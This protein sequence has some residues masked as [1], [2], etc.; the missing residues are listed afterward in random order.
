[1]N[2]ALRLITSSV[3]VAVLLVV[4]SG[5]A[6]IAFGRAAVA[7]RSLAADIYEP[8]DTQLQASTLAAGAPQDHTFHV[9]GDEDWAQFPVLAGEVVTVTTSNLEAGVDT[10]VTFYSEEGF[11]LAS[12]DDD[13]VEVSSR[14]TYVSTV[15]GFL[16]VVAEDVSATATGAYTLNLFRYEDEF[17]VDDSPAEASTLLPGLRQDHTFNRDGD[18]DWAQISV[19]AGRQYT[20]Y[21]SQLDLNVDTILEIYGSDTL[22]L[23]ADNDDGGVD[24]SSR[25][26]YTATQTGVNYVKVYQ[27]GGSGSGAYKL[28]LERDPGVYLN[29]DQ[30]ADVFTYSPSTGD[31]AR[32]AAD[33]SGGFTTVTGSWSPDWS[34]QPAQFN[35]DALTDFFLFNSSS[36]Q[37]FRMIDNGADGF[38]T[39]DTGFWWQGWE[40]YILDLNGD[41]ISDFFLYDPS[42]GTWFRSITTPTGF[43]YEQ[44][45]W[46][47]DWEIYP[48]KLNQDLLGDLFLINRTTGRWFW[49]YG[50]IDSGFSYPATETWFP[51]WVLYPGD[52]NGDGLDDLLLHDPPTGTYFVATTSDLGF[53][54]VQGG[55]SLGWTPHVADLD[56]D[57]KDDLFLHDP[58]TGNWFEMI[59]DGAGDFVNAGGETWSLGWEIFVTDFNGDHRDDIL[60]Y[61]PATGVWYQALN[62]TSG[63]FTYGSGAW[64]PGLQVVVKPPIR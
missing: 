41:G 34:V 4:P 58:A 29:G 42:T 37:W 36:G 8:D 40:R 47:P 10:R 51:G 45:G 46:N 11:Q 2:R 32:Q 30:N 14:L 22:T 21:T 28:T 33:G 48:V 17:E 6:E 9:D 1:M 3:A 60:L 23:L 53:T 52:Y 19:I 5:W 31:W 61:D 56:A 44:G 16:Y 25:V 63:T 50:D 38:T 43:V 24:L 35:T 20:I 49:V 62:L 57:G 27:F 12:N 7:P 13:G 18:E 26:I 54:Y 64:S 59:S 55:W 15:D 39:Q